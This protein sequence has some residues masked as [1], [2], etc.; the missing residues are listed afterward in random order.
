[1][2]SLCSASSIKD[3]KERAVN[4]PEKTKR[5]PEIELMK[6]IAIIGMIYVHVLEGS[7]EVFENAWELPGSIPYT[8]VE[9]LGGIPAAGVF[10]F[11]MGWGVS[12]SDR[13]T[14]ETYLKRALKLG[15]LLFPVNFFYAI[16]PGLI[17]PA[18]FGSFLDH[19]WAIIAFNIYS[20]YAV[21]M[22]F[23]ALIKK[24]K[25]NLKLRAVLSAVLILMVFAADMIFKPETFEGNQWIATL[26]GVFV[27]QN[28]YSWFPIV[29]WAVFPVMGYWAGWLYRRWNNRTKFAVTSLVIGLILVPVTVIILKVK[30]LPMASANPGW[31]EAID[32]YSLTALNVICAIGI[33]C[34][35]M[36]AVFGILTLSKGRIPSLFADMSRNVMGMFLM[37]WFFISPMLPFLLKVTD[38]WINVLIGTAVLIVTYIVVKLLNK[39]NKNIW[40]C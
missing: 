34:L 40:R 6:A 10:M 23:F 2:T 11:A 18:D 20:F 21:S 13:S 26:I 8:L 19:P 30:E 5:V 31:V 39:V 4:M 14:P 36:A 38:V 7:L 24:M 25:D 16:L 35:E 22:L 15:L 27:R 3:R 12:H 9:F 29:P 1:M 32:Y 37:Q 28:D 17:D 33:I